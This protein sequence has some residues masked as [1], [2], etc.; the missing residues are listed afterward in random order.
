MNVDRNGLEVL[1]RDES[2]RLLGTA[3]LDASP[4]PA[5]LPMVL[6]VNFR[7]DG[8]Q[9][10]FRTAAGTKLDAATDHAVVAFEVD[11]IDPATRPAG[12]WSSPAWP[13]RSPTRWSWPPRPS[14]AHPLGE[15]GRRSGRVDPGRPRV[16]PPDPPK[17]YAPAASGR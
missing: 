1:D 8:A 6:P 3:T 2:L 17:P 13:G 7:F 12:A 9:V 10:L 11:E 15:R 4:S 5:T 14:P 16:R